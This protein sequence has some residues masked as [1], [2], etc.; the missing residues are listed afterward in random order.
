[1]KKVSVR[2]IKKII[3]K[4]EAENRQPEAKVV[5][6]IKIIDDTVYANIKVYDPFNQT[7]IIYHNCEYPLDYLEKY[8]EEVGYGRS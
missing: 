3:E 5:G 4:I 2:D 7:Y 6:S 1:M 8:A